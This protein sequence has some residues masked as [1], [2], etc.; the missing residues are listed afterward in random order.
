MNSCRQRSTSIS[1]FLELDAGYKPWTTCCLGNYLCV[2]VKNCFSFIKFFHITA[3]LKIL[4]LSLTIKSKPI[5]NRSILGE[6]HKRDRIDRSLA[7]NYKGRYLF[8]QPCKHPRD[9]EGNQAELHA[10]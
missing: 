3:T 10:R 6:L 4:H 1:S 7:V 2:N 9:N 5:S 8:L